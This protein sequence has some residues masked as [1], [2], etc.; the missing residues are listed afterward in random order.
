MEAGYPQMR[1]LAMK[2]VY[3]A[4]TPGDVERKVDGI[5]ADYS[6]LM[7]FTKPPGPE[8]AALLSGSESVVAQ[9]RPFYLRVFRVA[10]GHLRAT[11]TGG[12]A[13]DRG[14]NTQPAR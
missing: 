3:R 14:A 4:N 8:W 9:A 7:I 12:G 2:Y 10:P 11:A 13:V 1:A 5:E 6:V